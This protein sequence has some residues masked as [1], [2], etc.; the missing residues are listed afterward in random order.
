[1]KIVDIP[2]D[3]FCPDCKVKTVVEPF[4]L[5]SCPQC[6]KMVGNCPIDRSHGTVTS[7]SCTGPG[8][9][10]GLIYHEEFSCGCVYHDENEDYNAAY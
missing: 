6:K 9:A 5:H 3:L 4:D 10:G 7:T 1:M 2:E 8:F